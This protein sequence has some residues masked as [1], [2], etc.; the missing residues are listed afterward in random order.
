MATKL[1]QQ[2]TTLQE[3]L[4][5]QYIPRS[6]DDVF[7]LTANALG[8][9]FGQLRILFYLIEPPP[10]LDPFDL[11]PCPARQVASNLFVFS[12]TR[13]A[14]YFHLKT[15]RPHWVPIE[16][17]SRP[18]GLIFLE[19]IGQP[20]TKTEQ[21]V[22]ALLATQAGH[23][24]I[25][26]DRLARGGPGLTPLRIDA[27]NHRL[28]LNGTALPLKGH[29]LAVLQLLYERRGSI[30]SRAL[31]ERELY[32]AEERER[33]DQLDMVIYRLRKKLSRSPV[34]IRTVRGRGYRLEIH[35]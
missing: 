20:L 24:L 7:Q 29:Q 21:K 11:I 13:H 28:F 15:E 23:H 34:R 30:C 33:R 8:E 35:E 3:V 18:L 25:H 9:I 32:L 17:V 6:Q 16:A 2:L 22:V 26:L 31:M 12:V 10:T 1:Q 19:R 27:V 5:S 4:A 14:S